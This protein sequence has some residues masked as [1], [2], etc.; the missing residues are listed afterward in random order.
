MASE[1]VFFFRNSVGFILI[2]VRMN[3]RCPFFFQTIDLMIVINVNP[4]YEVTLADVDWNPDVINNLGVNVVS[5]LP[6]LER[7]R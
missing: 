7:I 5:I 1:Q 2:Q 4:V 6:G 3:M